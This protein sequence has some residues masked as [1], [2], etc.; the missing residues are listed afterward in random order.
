MTVAYR[1]QDAAPMAKK[2][3]RG[4]RGK[5]QV[6]DITPVI[7]TEIR[8]MHRDLSN[9]MDRLEHKVDVYHQELERRVTAL[10]AA[11]F[12]KQ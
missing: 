12:R 3:G 9:R 1:M 6:V 2:S 4:G 8:G 7:L 11:M 5:Q 10:E